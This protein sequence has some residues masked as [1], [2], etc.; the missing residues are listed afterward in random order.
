MNWHNRYLQQAKWTHDLRAYLFDKTR[1]DRAQRVLEVG[2][3]TGAVLADLNTPASL[4][5]LDLDPAAL[6]ECRIHAPA[7]SLVRGD[8]LELPYPDECFDIVYSHF[9]LLWVRS[10]LQ[11]MREMKRVTRRDG[12]I[13]ALAE[14][15][16]SARVDKPDILTQVGKW[17][18][19]SLRR[20]GA[21]P[22][23]GARL[24]ETFHQ[25]GIKLV[26]T[27]PIQGPGMMRSAEEWDQEWGVIE[28]D[29]AGSV[30]GEEVRRMKLVDEQA[31]QR[32]ERVLH[33]PTYF[34]WGKT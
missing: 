29:L 16:Y 2:C 33:I 13:L 4:H 10:P 30:A 3:G 27:G 9:L 1:L 12:N 15:D 28:S 21:D 23:F 25:A 5:G 19:E 7:V 6:D 26:E 14:P 24:G 22:S 17:Q 18:T 11:A 32:G 20:Q 8:A 31:R 34:A